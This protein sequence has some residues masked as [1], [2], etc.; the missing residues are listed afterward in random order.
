[1][2]KSNVLVDV[3]DASE[4]DKRA[5]VDKCVSLGAYRSPP[6]GATMFIYWS[7]DTVGFCNVNNHIF[8]VITV[9]QALGRDDKHGWHKRGELP[10]VGTECSYLWNSHPEQWKEVVITDS[11]LDDM[12]R[13]VVLRQGKQLRISTRASDFR[14][15]DSER[16][17]FIERYSKEFPSLSEYAGSMYDSGIRYVN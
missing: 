12:F 7:G 6:S 17:K 2:L 15:I 4:E 13:C 5:V 14:P 8:P 11:G 1:M 9:D 10:P 16:D 3:R